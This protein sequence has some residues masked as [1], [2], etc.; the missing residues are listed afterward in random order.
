MLEERPRDPLAGSTWS[1]ATTVAGFARSSPNEVLMRYAR[2]LRRAGGVRLLDLGCG[3]GRNAVPLAREGWNVLGTDL[4]WPML[5]AAAERVRE[6]GPQ[7][8]L[9]VALAPMDLLP[10]PTAAS[11]SSWPMASGTWHVRARSSAA[12]WQKRRGWRSREPGSSSSPSHATR[13]PRPP[14]PFRARRTSSRTSRARPNASS[15][16]RSCCRSSA[17][18]DSFLIR[19]FR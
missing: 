15:P 2:A 17:R 9:R 19:R 14:D 6:E 11:M 8:R 13:W 5:R 12:P 7:G 10:P 1:A 4:S 16:P 3:A 18:L